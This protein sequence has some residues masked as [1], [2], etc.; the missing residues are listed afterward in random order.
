MYFKTDIQFLQIVQR[1]TWLIN[2]PSH[3][4]S[5]YRPISFIFHFYFKYLKKV[6]LHIQVRFS[7]STFYFYLSHFKVNYASNFTTKIKVI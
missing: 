2:W 6:I 3:P 1:N 4:F 7:P 5:R